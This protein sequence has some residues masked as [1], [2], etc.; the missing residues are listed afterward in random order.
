MR[1]AVSATVAVLLAVQ[2]LVVSVFASNV[3]SVSPDTDPIDTEPVIYYT[4]NYEP[5]MFADGRS[6][7]ALS[8]YGSYSAYNW[9]PVFSISMV[10]LLIL[11]LLLSLLLPLNLL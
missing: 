6:F 3:Y 5:G 4:E 10:L 1:K 11:N 9:N 8:S 7:F 2:L